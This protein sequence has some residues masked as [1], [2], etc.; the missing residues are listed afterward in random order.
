MSKIIEKQKAI[1]LR[2]KGFSYNE[3]RKKIPVSKSTLSLWLRSVGLAEKHMRALTERQKE[4]QQRA[5]QIWHEERLL[6]TLRIH[7]MA[8]NEIGNLSTREKWLIGVALYWAEGS[9]ERKKG[10]RVQFS[11]SD[12]RMILLFREWI[13]DHLLLQPS[14]IV[15]T[16]YIHENFNNIAGAIKFWADLLHI[17]EAEI[18]LY[19]K[20]HNLSPK[21]KNIGESYIGLIR[22]VVKKSIDINRKIEG[23]INGIISGAKITGE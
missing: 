3:I 5:V 7:E 8:E 18:K 21:R 9:K 13:L 20:K 11:N 14:D 23:W 4:S 19:V 2:K 10:T 1:E 17:N 6:R 22:L 15:Y 16:L 12:P